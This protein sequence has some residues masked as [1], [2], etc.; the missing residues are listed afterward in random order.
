M[1]FMTS[2]SSTK[3]NNH[4]YQIYDI[5]VSK[6]DEAYSIWSDWAQNIVTQTS[7]DYGINFLNGSH[8]YAEACKNDVNMI[9]DRVIVNTLPKAG[10]IWVGYIIFLLKS[11]CDGLIL[12]QIQ[13]QEDFMPF[14]SYCYDYNIL[15]N[16]YNYMRDNIPYDT[17]I[18][19]QSQSPQLF[20]QH[21]E[22]KHCQAWIDNNY[23]HSNDNDINILN[24]K[25]VVVF[26]DPFDA[27]YSF[28][29]Y[30]SNDFA[31]FGRQL[32][33]EAFD[34]AVL[35]RR[36]LK[37]EMNVF[38][39]FA[40]WIKFYESINF[41]YKYKNSLLTLFYEDL[42]LDR[43][44]CIQEIEM[45]LNINNPNDK[46][47]YDVNLEN[48]VLSL[49]SFDEMKKIGNQ[50]EAKRAARCF[51]NNAQSDE[52]LTYQRS[53]MYSGKHVRQD[54]GKIGQSIHDKNGHGLSKEYVEK[55]QQFWREEIE[56]ICGCK[57]Y[58]Q[59]RQKISFVATYA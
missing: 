29:K 59:L 7:A 9:R 50:L 44:K 48:K 19:S 17:A 14:L 25:M 5:D 22:Y 33:F 6:Y 28:Y 45:F 4:I 2:T 8:N 58:H 57:D 32:N 26:R 31:S 41:N 34:D 3:Q 39:F 35:N 53:F 10:T 43:Q 51:I 38:Q 27:I 49:S 23:N 55:V 12:N 11:R 42:I 21:S 16:D 56:P 36:D 47:K 40:S 18:W 24:N 15:V 37:H 30:K 54:G 1:N 52:K 20:C 46:E 13:E